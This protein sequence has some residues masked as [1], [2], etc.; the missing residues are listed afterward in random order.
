[1][2]QH[3]MVTVGQMRPGQ[4]G[5]VVQILG[6][7]GITNRLIALGVRP[8]KRITKMSSTFMRGPVTIQ[9]DSTRVA[10]GFGIANK[11]MVDL[12]NG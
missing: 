6:G 11:I 4:S 9:V 12:E 1:M 2:S 8:G 7:R 3:I 5:K 10:I